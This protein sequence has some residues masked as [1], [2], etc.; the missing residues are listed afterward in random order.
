[1]VRVSRKSSLSTEN[2]QFRVFG[3]QVLKFEDEAEQKAWAEKIVEL[4]RDCKPP[5]YDEKA[6]SSAASKSSFHIST[7]FQ[8]HS[9]HY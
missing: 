9:S 2:G 6:N 4:H 3:S 8:M 5:A 1:M 7:Y